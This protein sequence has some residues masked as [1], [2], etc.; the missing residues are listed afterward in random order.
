MKRIKMSYKNNRTFKD[1]F[2]EFI[3]NCKA[4]NLREATIK[5][6]E[7]S[8]KQIIKYLDE[9]IKI[10]DISKSTFDEFVVNVKKYSNANSQTLHTYCRD[11]KTILHFF[12]DKE[13][14]PTFKITLP[15][16]DKHPIQTYTDEELEKLLKKP[17]LKKCEFTEY[18]NYVIT[19]F[20]L[21][22]GVRLTSLTNIRI[23]DLNF[24]E[25]MV[26]VM[27]TKNRNAL[28]IPLN[29]EILKIL[30]EY[31]NYRQYR[32]EEDFLF[33]NMYGKQL[34]KSAITQ[35]LG[36]YNK[37]KGIEHTGIHRLRHTFAKKW[38]LAGNG[39]VGLKKI[40]GH[41]SLEMTQNYVNILVS[42]LKKDVDNYNI[43]Q[44]FN[45]NFIKM[46]NVKIKKNK[47]R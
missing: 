24:S 31:L 47:K 27:H 3:L 41:S 11:L 30:K 42:D 22:T 1:G 39:V 43:L 16:V 4:K 29:D 8:Y 38:V 2:N 14:T 20:F 10:S 6:Y 37:N 25:A 36:T 21:S 19:A 17:N 18:R 40:L 13:Y 28:V 7:V 12:M 23:R 35:A 26:N 32:N 9:N 44:E 5:H 33:C 45:K 46:D 34:T 15:R